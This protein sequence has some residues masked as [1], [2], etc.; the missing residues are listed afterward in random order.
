MLRKSIYLH[1]D[2]VT[3][4]AKTLLRRNNAYIYS[5]SGRRPPPRRPLQSFQRRIVSLKER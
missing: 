1:R 4:A 5:M 3:A 2:G